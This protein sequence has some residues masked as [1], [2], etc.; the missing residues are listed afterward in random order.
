MYVERVLVPEGNHLGFL[1]ALICS[2]PPGWGPQ[3]P[4]SGVQNQ[5]V[6]PDLECVILEI[7]NASVWTLHDGGLKMKMQP[8]NRYM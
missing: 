6:V 1:T 7:N 4:A 2:S 5:T 8:P 3:T